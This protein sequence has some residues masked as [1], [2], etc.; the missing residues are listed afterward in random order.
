MTQSSFTERDF[1][2]LIVNVRSVSKERSLLRAFPELAKHSEFKVQF[3][4]L[5]KDKVI[6]YVIYMYDRNTPFR[7]KYPD[8]LKRK[9]EA[10]K[11][12]GFKISDE[13]L[14]EDEVEV[15]LRGEN[16]KVNNMVCAYTRIYKNFK[17]S[18]FVTM[19]E[20]FYSLMRTI[21]DGELKNIGELKK[22][23][24]ELDETM[25]DLLNDDKN[26]FLIEKFLRYVEKQRL[27]LRPEDFARKFK[28][29]GSIKTNKE[30]SGS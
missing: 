18:F 30:I 24:K 22:T 3:E 2:K 11:E 4:K 19:E 25:N 1:N 27:S 9:L 28:T 29:D 7:K 8:I 13:G 14:F 6:R 23:Q 10:A 12:A 15:L 21:I 26:P 5:N 17:Y 16:S 20:I